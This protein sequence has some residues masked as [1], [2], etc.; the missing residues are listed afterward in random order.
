[1]FDERLGAGGPFPGA[2]DNDFGFRVLEAGYQIVY[3]PLPTLYHRAWRRMREYVPLHWKYGY[4]Q[5]A[6]Y[7]KHIQF[8]DRYMFQRLRWSVLKHIRLALRLANQDRREAAAHASYAAGM[9][10]GSM[11]WMITQRVLASSAGR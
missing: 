10:Y 9:L 3:D 11:K 4:G 7:A 6:Y 2:E 8:H 1:M 5:G